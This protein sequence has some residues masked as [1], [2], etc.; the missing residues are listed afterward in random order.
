M[1]QFPFI[2]FKQAID[3]NKVNKAWRYYKQIPEKSILQPCDVY[4]IAALCHSDST[5]RLDR[6]AKISARHQS[7]DEIKP[8]ISDCFSR[9]GN[10]EK[11]DPENKKHLLV[12]QAV[13]DKTRTASVT[14]LLEACSK[15]YGRKYTRKLLMSVWASVGNESELLREFHNLKC[16][17]AADAIAYKH[18]IRFY[19][20]NGNLDKA[21]ELLKET[22]KWKPLSSVYVHAIRALVNAKRFE[23]PLF[24]SHTE[25]L[26]LFAKLAEAN[27]YLGRDLTYLQIRAIIGSGD[28]NLALEKTAGLINE[29]DDPLDKDCCNELCQAIE[30]DSKSILQLISD[31]G[32]QGDE[33]FCNLCI[34]IL[35]KG[36]SF[37]AAQDLE[38]EFYERGWQVCTDTLRDLAIALFEHNQ[39]KQGIAV[40]EM[41][42]ERE[43]CLF[44][45]EWQEFLPKEVE[46]EQLFE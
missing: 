9:V 34:K 12:A 17:W 5:T 20:T 1:Q 15:I 25:A 29:F 24:Y 14:Q 32:Y 43:G 38:D 41:I 6:L 10:I 31:A 46:L 35:A 22:Q 21:L 27:A 8:L 7:V 11:V 39:P 30:A 44:S 26:E 4:S 23:F 3:A 33:A 16:I 42:K 2:N 13:K 19:A 37:K 18:L 40:L 36:G 45:E 28:L